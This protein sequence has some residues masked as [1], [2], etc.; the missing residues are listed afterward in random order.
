MTQEL[1]QLREIVQAELEH[2]PR[3][4]EPQGELRMAYWRYRMNSL[5]KKANREKT[6]REVLTESIASL[7]RDYPEIT[8]EY[9]EGFFNENGDQE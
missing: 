5:G 4:P 8:F 6:A 7:R 3:W 2:I 1:K 9:D